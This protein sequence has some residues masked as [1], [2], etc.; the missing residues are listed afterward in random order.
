MA[1]DGYIRVSRVGLR[2][3]ERFISPAVQRERIQA[4]AAARGVRVLEVFEELDESGGRAERPLLEE[5]IRRVE[6]GISRGIVVAHLDRFGRSLIDGLL[7]IERI[8]GASGSFFSVHDGFDSSTDTGRMILRILLSMA[9]WDLER[10]RSWYSVSMA[11][12]VARG[13]WVGAR[14]PVGYRKTRS[15][16]LRIDPRVAP[17]VVEVFRRRA[18]GESLAR[19]SDVLRERGVRTSAGNPGWD[20][21]TVRRL[22][23]N[24]GYLGVVWHG[25]LIN[26]RAH[27]PLID[28]ATWQ[29]AQQPLDRDVPHATKSGLLTGLVRCASCGMRMSTHHQRRGDELVVFYSCRRRFAFGLCAAPATMMGP[30]LENSVE[31]IVLDLLRARRRAPQAE[32][33]ACEADVVAAGRA[34][35][36]YR[37][38]DRALA[39][40]GDRSF[41]EGLSIRIDRLR[42]ARLQLAAVRARYATHDLPPSAELERDWFQMARSERREIISKTIDCVFVLPGRV[43]VQDRIFLCPAGT[44]PADL[45]HPGAKPRARPYQPRRGWI[46]PRYRSSRILR[47]STARIEAELDHLVE[48]RRLW[49]SP[50]RFYA[51]G[52][53]RLYEQI[54]RHGGEKHWCNRYGLRRHRPATDSW[55][56]ERIR[57]ALAPFLSEKATWPTKAEFKAAG[58]GTLHGALT[59]AGG[60]QRWAAEFQIPLPVR[61]GGRFRYWT[62]E[63][64]REQLTRLCAGRSTFP[65]GRELE[66]VGQGALAGVMRRHGGVDRWA[67]EM[68]LPRKRERARGRLEAATHRDPAVI[69]PRHLGGV[70]SGP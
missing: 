31:D 9:E 23:A 4:W 66:Q 48:G 49:P 24:R 41:A 15:G 56:D 39:V 65:S 28:A 25:E 27:P 32:L 3:G 44:A 50:Q 68:Q 29:R 30:P 36:R 47:W 46:Q 67:R 52:R 53:I 61:T 51:D 54:C 55:P 62:D 16:R 1:V 33:E 13:V 12:A 7:A 43:N 17:V 64:L 57:A 40:L 21:L 14:V 58:L 22:I 70:A 19:L 5:A 45:F 10:T 8:Q 37:D 34:L 60:G 38:S 26:E 63:L 59:Q 11:K 69:S 6:D 2:Q 35:V 18:A 42:D 20:G